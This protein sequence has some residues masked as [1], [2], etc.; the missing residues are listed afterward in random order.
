MVIAIHSFYIW[1]YQVQFLVVCG[2]Y[3]T[4]SV[5]HMYVS[6]QPP[7]TSLFR[8]VVFPITK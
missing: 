8:C 4:N 6:Y 2:Q 3:N 1:H 7:F 5:Q